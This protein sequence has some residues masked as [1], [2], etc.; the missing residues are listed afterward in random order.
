LPLAVL[1]LGASALGQG[2]AAQSEPPTAAPA[3]YVPTMTFDV[4]SIREMQQTDPMMVGGGFQAQSNTLRLTNV[5]VVW[6]IQTAYGVDSHQISGLPDWAQSTIFNVLAKPDGATTEKLAKLTKEQVT[7]EQQHMV[8]VM[9]TERLNFKSHWETKEGSIYNLVLAKNGPKFRAAGSLPPSAEELKNFGDHPIPP[10]YQRGDGRRGYEYVAHGCSMEALA[11]TLGAH[12]G[13][14]VV[15][16]TGLTGTYDFLLQY[17][18]ARPNRENDDP[19][20]WPALLDAVPDQLGLKLEPAKGSI[21][22]LV[23]DHIEKP[24]EN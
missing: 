20:V 14:P 19:S 10:L 5:P 13:T 17:H 8:L 16:K 7:L 12:M 23:I 6:L 2:S 21:P 15:D 24:S 9:L 3:A 4:A 22:K 11:G 1:A 18:G